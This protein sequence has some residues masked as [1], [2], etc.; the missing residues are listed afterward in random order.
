MNL[1]VVRDILLWCTVINFAVLLSWLLFFVFAHD[2]IF[3]L[4]SRWFRLQVGEFDA[5]HY[6]SM[7]IYKLGIILLNLV[8]YV[9]L[10]LVTWR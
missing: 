9:A 1:A 7:A 8:P 2:W 10:S 4:H 3:R 5:I 6:A